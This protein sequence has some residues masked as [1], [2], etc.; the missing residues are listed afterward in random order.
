MYQALNL[1]LVAAATLYGICPVDA[2]VL[3]SLNPIRGTGRPLPPRDT[4]SQ[5]PPTSVI[6]GPSLPLP[7]AYE[8][9]GQGEALNGT[10]PTTSSTFY[11]DVDMADLLQQPPEPWTPLSE[12]IRVPTPPK[13]TYSKNSMRII[14]ADADLTGGL[15]SFSPPSSYVDS[16][17]NVDSRSGAKGSA[18]E[19]DAWKV[20]MTDGEQEP[21][22]STLKAKEKVFGCLLSLT[23]EDDK[24]IEEYWSEVE[25]KI[26]YLNKTDIGS[27]KS[28]LR[29]AYSAHLGQYRKSGEPF[30]IH[31]VSVALLLADLSM[32]VETIQAG[33]LHDTV[34]DTDMEFSQIEAL[35]GVTVRRIV[36]GE[37][38]VSKLPKLAFSDYA[39]EQAENLRQMFVA[40]TE[41][42]RIIIVKLADRLHN[43]RT[44]RHMAPGKQQKISRETLDIFA[45]LAHRMGIRQFKSELEDTAF[46]Y[47]Y[48]LEYKR[49]N[50]KLRRNQKR[51]RDALELS[52]RLMEESIAADQQLKVEGVGAKVF[53]RTKE[54]YSLWLKMETKYESNLD[55]INDVVALRVVLEPGR[56]E[57]E[58]ESEWNQRGVWLCY[59]VLG[60]VQ[61]LPE[62]QPVPTS[63][64]DYISFP[65][66]NGYQSL[67]TALICKGQVVEVQIR[68]TSM[69]QVAEVGMAAHWAY[70]S[71]KRGLNP[72]E[73]DTPWLSSIKEWQA[74]NVSS[75]DFVE[76]VRREL[77]GK[78]V[79]VFLKNGKILNLARGATTIDAAFQ[80]HTEVGLRMESAE[81]N[82]HKVSMSYEL[83]NGDVVNIITGGGKPSLDWM[84]YAKS[85]NTRAKLRS[86][87][88]TKQKESLKEAGSIVINDFLDIHRTLIEENT[89]LDI[90]VKVED[91]SQLQLLLPGGTRFISV[92]ELCIEVG[93]RHDRKMLR[94][95]LASILKVPPAVFHD[96]ENREKPVDLKVTSNYRRAIARALRYSSDDPKEME[97]VAA[98]GSWGDSTSLVEQIEE[99]VVLGGEEDGVEIDV[100]SDKFTSTET[101]NPQHAETPD[102]FDSDKVEY[103]DP[104]HIC[105]TCLPVKGDDIIGTRP[106][107]IKKENSDAFVTTHRRTCIHASRAMESLK[108]SPLVPDSDGP[109]PKLV[110]FSERFNAPIE[111][112]L[113]AA[114]LTWSPFRDDPDVSYKCEIQIFAQD[115]KLLL[116]DCSE[117]VS[118]NAFIIQTGS[119]TKTEH[120][121]LRFLV[122]VKD[123]EHVQ[124]IMNELANVRSVFSVERVFGTSLDQ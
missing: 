108:R 35:F 42:Y 39:D 94:S 20:L 43:M 17:N 57:N 26:Q 13:T 75:R 52:Q 100:G 79:F 96:A 6:T 55:E 104:D 8:D 51:Y 87:F 28:A 64:K 72:D 98:V 73:Y 4:I 118:D 86:Y 46:M 105:P 48:P 53:G 85:R 95:I 7:A 110:T 102:D 122:R 16:M 44:L 11:D 14:I 101:S 47:L 61:H 65:K 3:P 83:R 10:T 91:V 111:A 114:P 50:R 80:I 60:L 84:R 121:E 71:Y 56:R 76:S 15:S 54:L 123:L 36:E 90:G 93:K 68:T 115:R 82:G 27:V 107:K 12:L 41:D 24:Q 119:V 33:L 78:R 120:A 66:P 38:K 62:C 25:P 63:V 116:S 74:E 99:N 1:A 89:Q 88:R 70:Q 9:G 69:H 5:R 113:E 109:G 19:V 45:P 49:L 103:A 18:P 77:L 32:D 112:A 124:K 34:E 21:T 31:P 37:T 92:D 67:H 22:M 58:S 106:T 30:I 40:M 81:I 29:V 97:R 117:V 59:H 2:F 23:A